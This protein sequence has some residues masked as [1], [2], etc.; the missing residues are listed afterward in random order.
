MQQVHGKNVTVAGLGRFGGGV[1]VA[2][3]LVRQGAKVLVT[4]RD[5]PDKLA[6][7]VAQLA[8]EPIEYR[9]GEHRTGD[10]A[11]ADLVVASPAI[12]PSN[13][14][15]LAAAAAGVPV[16]TEIRLFI[17]RCPA[18]IVGVT[19]TKGKSTTASML[20]RMLASGFTTHL[21]G[22]IGLSLLD[23]L[24]T[25]RADD[26][27][28]LELSSFMLDYLGRVGWSPAVA[29]VTMIGVD[30][31]E[32]HGSREAYV[33]AKTNIVRFQRLGDTAVLCAEDAGAMALADVCRKTGAKVIAYRVGKPIELTLLGAHNQ[34]NA[35]GAM[36]AAGAMG[37]DSDKAAKAVR[38]FE[39][40]P[41]RL[42]PVH[43]AAGVTFYDDSIATVPESAMAAVESFPPRTVIQIVGGYNAKADIEKMCGR[44][45]QRAK[46]VLCIGD[47]GDAI[48]AMMEKKRAETGG[49]A[50]PIVQ[51]C[52][53]LGLAV[54]KARDIA[55]DGDVVLL[56]P[57]CKSY[58]QFTNFEKRGE[59][60]SR[61]VRS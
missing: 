4:D 58:D 54:Q 41:H 56:S 33:A 9:L 32:W 39:A 17:E 60:F 11:R 35:A 2:R 20:A 3:W 27:V 14:Y 48:V 42:R 51:R 37:I 26:V 31:V 45:A 44:L 40:L 22:N 24:P 1:A 15:L 29:L 10:F 7:S 6:D 16:T 52:A 55:R 5:G 43:A 47:T 13:P 50:E 38:D 49:G 8:G 57:G 28:V 61:L 19:G 12:P 46:A 30:H 34:L 59:E 18:R 25:M 53:N 23:K 21:G 36:A